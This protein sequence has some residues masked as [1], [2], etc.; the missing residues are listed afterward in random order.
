MLNIVYAG[1]SFSNRFLRCAERSPGVGVS[2]FNN[3]TSYGSADAC[4]VS[5]FPWLPIS[6]GRIRG[7]NMSSVTNS[8]HF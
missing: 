4:W 5:E 2:I 8:S 7:S 3:S 6:M 1:P